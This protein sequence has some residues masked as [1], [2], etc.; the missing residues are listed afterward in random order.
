MIA[1]CALAM[2]HSRGEILHSFWAPGSSREKES[3]SAIASA[4]GISR[5]AVY[6]IKDDRAGMEAALASWGL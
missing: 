3:I 1:N 4:T 2:A 6:R 5:Q